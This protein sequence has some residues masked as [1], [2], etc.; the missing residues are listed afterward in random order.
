ML[1]KFSYLVLV[2]LTMLATRPPTWAAT[3]FDVPDRD[4]L[5]RF[6]LLEPGEMGESLEDDDEPSAF[7]LSRQE[8]AAMRVGADY[9]RQ[10]LQ[11]GAANTS[12]LLIQ[13][14]TVN[15]YDDN[16][17]AYSP[18]LETGP[19]AGYTLLS[20]ALVGNWFG[21]SGSAYNNLLAYIEINRG[22]NP[23]GEWYTGPMASLPQNGDLA[24]LASTLLHELG[25]ALG[26]MAAIDDNTASLSDL[27]FADNINLWTTGLRDI[28]GNAAQPGMVISPTP[29]AGAFVTNGD[30]AYSGVYFT[31][32][33]VQEVLNGAEIAFASDPDGS[34]DGGTPPSPVPGLPING[35]EGGSPEFSHIELQNSLMSHQAYRNW[36]TFMEAE[37]A[38]MQDVGLQIDRRDWYGYSIYNSGTAGDLREFVNT[39]PYYA[40]SNGTRLEGQPNLTPWGVGLHVYGSYNNITQAADLLADGAY[41][42]GIRVEGSGNQL[43]V[44]PGVR[45][46]ADGTGGTALLVSYG[47]EHSLTLQGEAQA[48]GQGGIAARFDFGDNEMGNNMEYRGSYIRTT[49]DYDEAT[50]TWDIDTRAT[51]PDELEGPLVNSFNVTGRLAGSAAAIYISENALVENINIMSGAEISGD[52]ISKWDPEDPRIQYSGPSTD[53]HTTLTFGLTPDSL[54]AATATPDQNFALTLNDGIYGAESL[55]MSVEGGRLNIAGPVEVY[56]LEN[57]AHLALYGLNPVMVTDNF[58]NTAEATLETGFNAAGQV[59]GVMAAGADVDGNWFLTPLP[60]FYSSN[61]YIT[62]QTAVTLTDGTPVSGFSS[63]ALGQNSS[64]TLSFALLSTD[65]NAPTISASRAPDAYS[66]YAENQGA[67]NLGRSLPEIAELARGD[68]RALFTALDFSRPDGNTVQSA[69]AQLSAEPYDIAARTALRQQQEFNTMLLGRLLS[70]E[71]ARRHAARQAAVNAPAAGDTPDNEYPTANHNPGTDAP[72]HTWQAW[73]TP[74]GSAARQKDHNG[75]AGW[76][77]SGI[78]AL[79]GIEQSLDSGLTWGLHLAF[80]ARDTDINGHHDARLSTQGIYLGSQALYNP[81]QWDGFYLTGQARLGV[82]ENKLQRNISFNG[83]HRQN[84]SDWTGLAGGA[85]LG[86]GKDWTWENLT[87]GPL[88]WAEYG[89][90]HR[91]SLNETGGGASSL[92]LDNELYQSLS[93]ALGAHVGAA[94]Q[95]TDKLDLQADLLAAWRHELLDNPFHSSAV[96]QGYE[97][98]GFESATELVGR[99]ALLLQGSMRI[100]HVDNVFTQL[101]LGGEFFRTDNAAIN[102]SLSVGWEF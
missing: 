34:R 51:L 12:P 46:H 94:A 8:L 96:F 53:L 95:L 77:S 81:E 10:L 24:D 9:W 29:A 84:E 13:V 92:D 72:A 23:S 70:N 87:A 35:W 79:G 31:G 75:T 76:S 89:F 38:A 86:A 37:L 97:S 6:L 26:M 85:L 42:L 2:I 56:S 14:R 64:P 1:R 66:R 88:A 18:T 40:R 63:V 50:R 59:T 57:N 82:E 48:L 25:H 73:L 19:F 43:S 27:S 3:P 80:A 74:F 16:A 28:N 68:M 36:N 39:N 41:A 71:A 90:A 11:P 102:V 93:F 60:D 30:I 78:G 4:G 101:E 5:F 17:S 83:Y 15:E 61:N 20:G 100:D 58:T 7:D 62:P 65:P 98:V 47:K 91:P 67:A 22:S 55:D 99:D 54:G 49:G 69:L 33:H 21:E 44:A 45:V 52:I 32:K